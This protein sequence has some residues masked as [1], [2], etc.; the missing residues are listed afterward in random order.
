MLLRLDK[1]LSDSGIASRRDAARL[2]KRGCV[3]A[4][5][6]PA[7]DAD[8]KYD[9]ETAQIAVNGVALAYRRHH[10]FMMNKPA[11]VV[12]ATED[13]QETTVLSLLREPDESLSLFPAGRLDK[14]AEGLLLLTDDGG[15]AHSVISPSKKVDKT[16]YIR[17][18]APFD[19]D[20][21]A[22]FAR[23]VTLGD[24][25]QCRPARLEPLPD[26]AC[27]AFVTLREG[28]YHQVK[29]MTAARGKRVVYLKRVQI[30][31]LRLDGR[32]KPGEYRALT[33]E[34]CASILQNSAKK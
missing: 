29:R 9:P 18:D 8:R 30:G 21:A 3:T 14:D 19:A 4:D 1:I 25:A 17:T 12:S 23:G 33:E 26:G 34:E 13:A 6:V 11:G 27:E 10:Y 31:G 22:A 20:D 28:K 15:F 2:V 5:G 7:P 32:L 24:G 16:Y